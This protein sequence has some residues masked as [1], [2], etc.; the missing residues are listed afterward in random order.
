MNYQ[1]YLPHIS[2]RAII[3]KYWL[4]SDFENN[5]SERVFPEGCTNL[6]F[7]QTSR[8]SS[9]N[10]MGINSTFS[11][12]EAN[13][14][15]SYFGVSFRPGMLSI[16]TKESLFAIKDVS[17][18]SQEIIPQLNSMSIAQLEDCTTV[19][20]KINQI[21]NHLFQILSP[22]S[23]TELLSG[24]VANAIQSDHNQDTLCL[25]EKHNISLRQLERKFKKEVGLSM[26]LYMRL[27][28]FNKAVNTI[29]TY[30]SASFSE[31]A[32]ELGFY[33]HAHLSNEIKHFSG[34]V[35]SSF[36]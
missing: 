5:Y 19:G 17:V 9:L 22:L 31:I 34:L 6:V 25:A 13:A 16:L 14:D 23:S 4:M 1:E 32:Y 24:S 27:T 35:P 33:D 10:V 36:R 3:D 11:D 29:Q 18:A 8:S 30:S 26:K 7:H 15:D 21:E 20:D 12:F 2:L 28:R